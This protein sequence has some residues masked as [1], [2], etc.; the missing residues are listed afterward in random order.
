MFAAPPARRASRSSAAL[1]WCT[2]LVT[3][4]AGSGARH[5][6]RSNDVAVPTSGCHN[7][8]SSAR[9]SGTS[10]QL[11]KGEAVRALPS[12]VPR[13]FAAE[14]RPSKTPTSSIWDE[15]D[16]VQCKRWAVVTTI[17]EPS[18][19]INITV[20]FPGWCLV[21]V[22][23]TRRRIHYSAEWL[24]PSRAPRRTSARSYS[25]GR[26]AE[27]NRQA[28]HGV[29]ELPWALLAQNIGCARARALHARARV[30][31]GLSRTAA[32]PARRAR[33]Q[34]PSS[35][36]STARDSCGLDDDNEL[37]ACGPPLHQSGLARARAAAWSRRDC[38][39]LMSRPPSTRTR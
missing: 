14:Q 18:N 28:E 29:D 3:L 35:P 2:L 24:P 33:P 30:G 16:R 23:D 31:D 21:V 10:G 8:T 37:L 27:T 13:R 4:S 36:S 39:H 17:F 20:R 1:R 25:S 19:A 7:S 34:P 38:S 15:R 11:F 26:S 9:L 12:D 5:L 6:K 22:G 32:R